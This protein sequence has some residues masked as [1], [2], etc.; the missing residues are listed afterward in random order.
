MGAKAPAKAGSAGKTATKQPRKRKSPVTSGPKQDARQVAKF[1]S[2]KGTDA[3]I[4]ARCAAEVDGWDKLGGS[5][6]ADMVRLMRSVTS[7]R[8]APTL[9]VSQNDK[10]GV[11]VDAEPDRNL[12]LNVLRLAEAFGS[13]TDHLI[14]ERVSDL[15]NTQAKTG[16]CTTQ[17]LSAALAFIHGGQA[18][19]PV[20]SA[21]L[22]QMTGSHA[23]S[24]RA[25]QM[26]AKAEWVE[27][28]QMW[29]NLS[30]KLMNLYTRQAETLA[31][32][33]RGAEQTVRHV[34]VDAR[35]QTAINC[36]PERLNGMQ[37][38]YEQH[39]GGAFG[40]AMLGYDPAG[41][42]MPIPGDQGQ[43]A[44]PHSRRKID[45]GTG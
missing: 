22:V 37:Q 21:L 15:V 41:N 4:E 40:P 43:E 17:S 6:R 12:T 9:A 24:M 23:A 29:G 36:P 18:A 10:G 28:A 32:L 44:V 13:S 39:E 20:Q 34:Y 5:G 3:E 30:V 38:P 16:E 42:G 45:G 2:G 7:H 1:V 26:A 19:D 8:N 11:H 25:L 27:Q 33:Q 31:K 14:N 35:T